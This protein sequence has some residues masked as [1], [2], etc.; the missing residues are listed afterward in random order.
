[1]KKYYLANEIVEEQ[2]IETPFGNFPLKMTWADGMVGVCPIFS[3]KKLAK[4]YA[5]K[6][7]LTKYTKVKE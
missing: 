2:E 5:G 1:M 6:Y 7:P 3:N 4:K